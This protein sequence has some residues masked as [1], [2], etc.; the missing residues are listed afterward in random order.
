LFRDFGDQRFL[1]DGCGVVLA[2]AT[3]LEEE[4][5]LDLVR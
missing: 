2:A 4:A 3:A 5:L 1:P